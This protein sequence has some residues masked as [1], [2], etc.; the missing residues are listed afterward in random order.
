LSAT[1]ESSKAAGN[2]DLLSD[3]NLAAT[4]ADFIVGDTSVINMNGNTLDIN[5]ELN[6]STNSV[7][8]QSGGSLVYGSWNGQGTINP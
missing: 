8:N 7:L 6:M 2:L 1:L 5:D 3:L 4:G